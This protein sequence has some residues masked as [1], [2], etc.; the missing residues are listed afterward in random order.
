MESHVADD[1]AVVMRHGRSDSTD[2]LDS[3]STSETAPLMTPSRPYNA[4]PSLPSYNELYYSNGERR[5][6][7]MSPLPVYTKIPSAEPQAPAVPPTSSCPVVAL[8]ETKQEHS[9]HL[10]PLTSSLTSSTVSDLLSSDV[11]PST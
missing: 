1:G 2:S 11:A 4:A 10:E 9:V 3:E 5:I 6:D 7:E 8:G